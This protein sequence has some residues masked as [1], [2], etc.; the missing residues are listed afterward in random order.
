MKA[1]SVVLVLILVVGCSPYIYKSEING[2]SNGMNNLNVAYSSGLKSLGTERQEKQRWDW[3]KNKALVSLT[4]G[5]VPQATGGPDTTP[6]CALQANGMA[7]PAP[8]RTE[9]EAVKAAPIIKAL[10]EYAD[11]LAAVTNSK[12]QQDLE[13]AQAQFKNSIQNLAKQRD[14]KLT[15]PAGPISELFSGVM[16]AALNARRFAILKEGVI[17]ANEPVATLGGAMGDTL[18]A[19]RTARANELRQYALGLTID[20]NS[21]VGRADYYSLL[22]LAAGKV[23]AIEALR[24]SDPGKA[25]QDMVKAHNELAL[26]FKDNRRQ[27]QEVIKSVQAF[28][29]KAKAVREAFTE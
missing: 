27:A 24:I 20:L 1:A 29:D 8:S 23:N 22:N 19:L 17:A 10:R 28:V 26:A 11:A 15:K 7:L 4:E 3:A 18:E 9:T 13:E 5:C 2:F 21:A 16:T 6:P 12:D 14:T 25:A